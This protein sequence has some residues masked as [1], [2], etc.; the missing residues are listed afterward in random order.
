[1]IINGANNHP[2]AVYLEED[3]K[4]LFLEGST[5]EQRQA[6]ARSLLENAEN[7]IVYRHL[8]SGDVM[9]FNRQPTLHKPSLM[10]HIARVLPKEQTIRMHYAN[11]SSYNA[12]FD[13]D[14]MNLHFVQNHLARTEAYNLSLNDKQYIVPT[15]K[16]PIRGLIQDMVLS[17]VFVSMKDTFFEKSEYHQLL[18]S[19]IKTLFDNK[20]HFEKIRLVMPAIIKPKELWTGKQVITTIIK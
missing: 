18:Y 9:L 19:A 5:L 12:D 14:E 2:G 3:G 6:L 13:G 17:A 20:M 11:C 4:K 10:S 7:K 8:T 1:L 16:D 15:S